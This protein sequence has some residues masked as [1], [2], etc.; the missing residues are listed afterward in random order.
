MT[1]TQRRS[2]ASQR[3]RYVA[4]LR[5]VSE[6]PAVHPEPEPAPD[7]K[8]RA[9]PRLGLPALLVALAVLM[10]GLATW[11]GVQANS[12]DTA[13]AKAN[14]ALA[15]NAATSQVTGQ[16]TAIVNGIF[17]YDYAQPAKSEDLAKRSLVGKAVQDYAAL[18]KPV[19]Q[20]AAEGKLVL[21]VAT[22]ASGVEVLSADRA[23]VLVFVDQKATRADNG[24]TSSGGGQLAVDAVLSEG[25]WKVGGITAY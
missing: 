4:G 6:R 12:L 9:R 22:V 16:V 5:P 24:Q 3:K 15:D 10:T 2:P 18:I 25:T 8:P 23:R 20:Q 14:T 19:R 17:S 7:P 11:F 13:A 21:T 1:I